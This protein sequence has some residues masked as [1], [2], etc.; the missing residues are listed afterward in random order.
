MT[1]FFRSLVIF[2]RNVWLLTA[3]TFLVQKIRPMRIKIK[4]NTSHEIR[5]HFFKNLY[6][7]KYFHDF[8]LPHVATETI[9]L[10][11]SK[12]KIAQRNYPKTLQVNLIK[13]INFVSKE[14]W[15]GF[16]YYTICQKNT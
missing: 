10:P 11:R 1:I 5:L 9:L 7:S 6:I 3:S 15:F 12:A 4:T 16:P 8:L 2:F 13:L 14:K